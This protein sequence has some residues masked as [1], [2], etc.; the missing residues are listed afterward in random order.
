MRVT[1]WERMPLGIGATRLSHAMHEL[2]RPMDAQKIKALGDKIVMEEMTAPRE[3]STDIL[4]HK[5]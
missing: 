5:G 2:E 4:S 3:D 1:K